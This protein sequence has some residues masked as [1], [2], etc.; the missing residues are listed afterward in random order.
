MDTNEWKNNSEEKK[1]WIKRGNP[2]I[3]KQLICKLNCA[4]VRPC[5]KFW[6]HQTYIS[7]R[8]INKKNII[9]NQPKEESSP[10]LLISQLSSSVELWRYP[11]F[12]FGRFTSVSTSTLIRNSTKPNLIANLLNRR[13]KDKK[14]V[15]VIFGICSGIHRHIGI[16][17]ELFWWN[18]S[19]H[20][21]IIYYAPSYLLLFQTG[22]Q[23]YLLLSLWL[24]CRGLQTSPAR[25]CFVFSHN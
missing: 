23:W 9:P 16:H 18:S 25:S 12:S 15:N 1:N 7:L 17:L 3:H 4:A 22:L 2:K 8:K 13:R 14:N 24:N 6:V 21:T 20:I 19:L 10:E 5:Y 11:R